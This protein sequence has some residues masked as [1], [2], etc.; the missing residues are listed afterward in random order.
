MFVFNGKPIGLEKYQDAIKW[1][2]DLSFKPRGVIEE[3]INPDEYLD[4]GL[5][6][7]SYAVYFV[8]DEKGYPSIL[9]RSNEIEGKNS[10]AIRVNGVFTMRGEALLHEVLSIFNGE[11]TIEKVGENMFRSIALKKDRWEWNRKPFIRE[12]QF[13]CNF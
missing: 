11:K 5:L 4:K 8:R 6:L 1:V 3:W 10:L 9:V 2:R 12:R 13:E 7:P